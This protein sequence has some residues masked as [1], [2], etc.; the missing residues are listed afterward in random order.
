M[1]TP[2]FIE[3]IDWS[4]LRNQKTLL[5][6]TINNKAVSPMHK[7]ALEGILNTLDALQ[8]Y[9]VD[10]MDIDP[11]HVFDYEQEDVRDGYVGIEPTMSEE[12]ITILCSN[13]NSDNVEM[14]YWVNPNTDEIGDITS[15]GDDQDTWCSDCE[16][17]GG[18]Y[19][20]KLIPDAEVIGYQ[21]VSNDD[22][23]EIHPMM[24]GSFC[25]YSL[26]QAK[27][28]LEDNDGGWR[29]LT[30]WTG[31]VEEPTMMF[32]GSPRD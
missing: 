4:E 29:L 25:V 21:V 12:K 27:E 10:E 8:D 32:E 6:E 19:A 5:L 1:K 2:Y 13:C 28:M 20:S 15:D 18:V 16:T 11:M 31:D 3:K 9:A 23:G 22:N 14:K 17:H 24:D 7:E 26:S 30:V